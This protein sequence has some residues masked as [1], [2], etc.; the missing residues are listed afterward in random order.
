MSDGFVIKLNHQS[1]RVKSQ[2][3]ILTSPTCAWLPSVLVSHS[4]ARRSTARISKR[5]CETSPPPCC[6]RPSCVFNLCERAK[7]R[8]RFGVVGPLLWSPLPSEN[9]MNR[10]FDKKPKKSLKSSQRHASLGIPT[11]IAVGPLGFQA[12]L[13]TDSQGQQSRSCRDL[14]VDGPDLTAILDDKDPRASRI[15]FHDKKSEDQGSAVT[16]VL[17]TGSVVKSSEQGGDPTSKDL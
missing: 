2:P 13:D 10:L 7:G 9:T 8:P 14:E 1:E 6:R 12:E 4:R 5:L 16:N 15:V 17:A 3:Y 11:N